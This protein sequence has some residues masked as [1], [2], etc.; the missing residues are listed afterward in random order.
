MPARLR[1]IVLSH[2]VVAPA[3]LLVQAD[4]PEA[5]RRRPP[6]SASP[7][8]EASTPAHMLYTSR[9]VAFGNYWG[10]VGLI[11]IF[12]PPTNPDLSGLRF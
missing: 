9:G 5:G 10:Q 4:E 12:A 8:P 3:V 11:V 1:Q 6:R 7:T 2:L